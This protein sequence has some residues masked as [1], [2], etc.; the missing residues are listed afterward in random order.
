[1]TSAVLLS[2]RIRFSP[3]ATWLQLFGVSSH[4]LKGLS[5]NWLDAWSTM[6]FS[7]P[8]VWGC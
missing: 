6:F 7:P 1:M 4:T 8:S 5:V 3:W 2:V